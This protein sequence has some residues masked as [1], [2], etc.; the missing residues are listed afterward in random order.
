[1]LYAPTF[2]RLADH[3]DGRGRV[4]IGLGVDGIPD[5]LQRRCVGVRKLGGEG[6]MVAVGIYPAP[7][8][9]AP[10]SR[11]A[12]YRL[13]LLSP[14]RWGGDW[15]PPLAQRDGT[16][17]TVTAA[18][19]PLRLI[20]AAVGKYERIGGWDILRRQ[21]KPAE[22]R[23]PAGSAYFVRPERPADLSAL[24]GRKL[25]LGA[26]AG[27]GQAAVGRWLEGVTR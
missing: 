25:G 17:W 4:G 13:L 2:V 22:A 15:L 23:V 20:S 1:M 11:G 5:D 8:G 24:H 27:F 18:G 10:A 6:R 26:G 19:I 3:A 7:R 14:A 9:L 16:G 12:Q 21:P